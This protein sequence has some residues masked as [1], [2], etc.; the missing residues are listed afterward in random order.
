MFPPIARAVH[1][2]V[3]HSGLRTIRT[4]SNPLATVLVGGL[5]EIGSFQPTGCTEDK[6][7]LINADIRPGEVVCR[8]RR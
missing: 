5:L 8:S 3:P 2:D 6:G 1:G 4:Y 7:F